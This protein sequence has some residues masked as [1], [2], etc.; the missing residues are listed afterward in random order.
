MHEHANGIDFSEVAPRNPKN[1]SI[2]VSETLEKDIDSTYEFKQILMRQAERV[3]RQ[4]R[5]EKLYAKTIALTFKTSDFITYS[6]Q[7]KLTNPNGKTKQVNTSNTKEPI[8]K[9]DPSG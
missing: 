8:L 9:W 7:I 3:G 5:Y 4:A 6:H 2:S 1:K